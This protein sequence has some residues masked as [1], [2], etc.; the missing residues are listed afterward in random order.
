MKQIIQ[1]LKKGNTILEEAPALQVKRGTVLF[2]TTRSLVSLGTDYKSAPA[3]GATEKQIF[4]NFEENLHYEHNNN[5]PN[6]E[7]Q[8]AINDVE[9]KK[10][11]RTESSDELF[12]QLG[13]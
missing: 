12:S 1:D 5:P 10:G 7:T 6:Y 8:K 13:I 9:L 3:G 2:K 11:T 4:T